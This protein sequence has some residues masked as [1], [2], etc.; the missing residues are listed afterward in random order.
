MIQPAVENSAAILARDGAVLQR[1]TLRASA[2]NL[3]PVL[4]DAAG[5]VIAPWE[6]E[7]VRWPPEVEAALR[8]GGYLR[9]PQPELDLWC[10]CAD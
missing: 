5:K 8:R 2:P 3:A 7:V 9:P 10:N 6:M 4:V 1:L